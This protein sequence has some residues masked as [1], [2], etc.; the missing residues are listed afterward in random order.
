MEKT[1][2]HIRIWPDPILRKKCKNIAQVDSDVREL[3]DKMY[4]LMKKGDGAGLAATQVGLDIS[5]VVIETADKLFKLANP[6]ILKKEGSIVL[7]EGCLSFPGLMLSIKR[8]NKVWVSALD[9]TGNPLDIE[10]EG[11][12]SVIFQH[13]IDHINGILFI[14]RI[15]MWKKI[16][17]TLRLRRIKRR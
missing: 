16:L 8:A 17:I 6:R 5:L 12:L 13:E 1:K 3:L 9:E 10:A 7:Q 4:Y 11:V 15:P 2:L 14:D